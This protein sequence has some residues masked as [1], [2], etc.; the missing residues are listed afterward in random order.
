MPMPET[1]ASDRKLRQDWRLLREAQE[2]VAKGKRHLTHNPLIHNHGVATITRR[3][4]HSDLM[5]KTRGHY[6]GP[7]A[8]LEVVASSIGDSREHSLKAEHDAILRL[9]ELPETE[10]LI[11]LFFLQERARKQQ[12]VAAEP[13]PIHRAGVVGA[14]VMGAGIAYWLRGG[15]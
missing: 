12:Y 1:R 15:R 4:A 5:E 10:Q 9:S 6:P 13:R 8:A 11:R 2:Y 3:L 7:E 14:G